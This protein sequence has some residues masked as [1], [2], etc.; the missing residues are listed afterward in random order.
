MNERGL[1]SDFVAVWDS[2]YATA[3]GHGCVRNWMQT[4]FVRCRTREIW[5]ATCHAATAWD[6]VLGYK[7]KHWYQR[8]A[9]HWM[10]PWRAAFFLTSDDLMTCKILSTKVW[11]SIF[12]LNLILPYLPCNSFG[13]FAAMMCHHH[14]MLGHDRYA[15]VYNQNWTTN[16]HA[17]AF[18]CEMSKSNHKAKEK[19]FTESHFGQVRVDSNRL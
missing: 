18:A 3:L 15:N 7:A 9:K 5:K 2:M 11:L 14:H 1:L 6:S 10:T 17:V 16:L 12:I 4:V 8:F 13:K 19:C